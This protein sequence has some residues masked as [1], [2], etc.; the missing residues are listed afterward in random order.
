MSNVNSSGYPSIGRLPLGVAVLAILIGIFGFFVLLAG[1]VLLVFGT[2]LVFGAGTVTVFGSGSTLA[3]LI[4]L[5]VGAMTLAVATGLWD[6][7]LWALAFA[8]IILG[9][10]GAVEFLSQ[11]WFGFFLVGVLLVYL[12][13]VSGHFD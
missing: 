1:V 5:I 4:L 12:V 6:Q 9:F 8:V 11:A 10:Y 3:G 2:G 7:E 13:A